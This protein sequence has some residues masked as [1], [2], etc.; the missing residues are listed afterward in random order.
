MYVSYSEK[1]D[2]RAFDVYQITD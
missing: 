2:V 1:D